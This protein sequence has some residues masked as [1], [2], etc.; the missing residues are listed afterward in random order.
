MGTDVGAASIRGR[1][2]VCGRDC[3]L[4]AKLRVGQLQAFAGATVPRASL[5]KK[6]ISAT[7]HMHATRTSLQI[8]ALSRQ[9]NE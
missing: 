3:S 8:P 9:R 2:G 5:K 4:N 7:L 1:G 6:P